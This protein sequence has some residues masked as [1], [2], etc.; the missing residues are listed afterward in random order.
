[1]NSF[2]THVLETMHGRP[3][4]GIELALIGPDGGVSRLRLFGRVSLQDIGR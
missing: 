2:S 3:A 4:A 1:M